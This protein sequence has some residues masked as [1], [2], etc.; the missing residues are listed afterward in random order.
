MLIRGVVGYQDGDHS[1]LGTSGFAFWSGAGLD[2]RS[3]TVQGQ[4]APSSLSTP[5][6]NTNGLLNVPVTSPTCPSQ[7]ACP[8]RRLY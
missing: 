7:F 5:P 4:C 8:R 3:T 1:G 2:S 6:P